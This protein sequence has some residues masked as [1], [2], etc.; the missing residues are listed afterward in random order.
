MAQALEDFLAL[1]GEPDAQQ[2]GNQQPEQRA[3]ADGPLVLA[4]LEEL[5]QIAAADGDRAR[6]QYKRRS[7]ELMEHARD[8]RA[9]K[10]AQQKAESEK[11][12]RQRLEQ[13]L[14]LVAASQPCASLVLGIRSQ[15]SSVTP[16]QQASIHISLACRR[17][18]R[19]NPSESF[20]KRQ[21]RSVSL[22]SVVVSS[23]IGSYRTWWHLCSEMLDQSA[24]SY[25][26][27]LLVLCNSTRPA[28]S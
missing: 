9:V 24:S 19:G 27:P 26:E 21:D 22:P 4:E 17:R 2:P 5:Q 13:Q 28:R 12:K 25:S 11:G 14:Q 1:F 20:A 6:P 16:Q 10:I 23:R 8:C 15:S 18:I 3:V 7:W